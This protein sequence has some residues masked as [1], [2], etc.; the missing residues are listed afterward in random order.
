MRE[1]IVIFL[2]LLTVEVLSAQT[3][4]GGILVEYSSLFEKK[5]T[6]KTLF[7]IG[8]SGVEAHKS[9][10]EER[11]THSGVGLFYCLKSDI[12]C[13]FNL[14]LRPGILLIEEPFFAPQI[15]LHLRYYANEGFYLGTGLTLEIYGSRETD[16]EPPKL[17]LSGSVSIGK[18]ILKKLW[19][20]FSA[21]KTVDENYGSENT[22]YSNPQVVISHH[23]IGSIKL[24]FEYNL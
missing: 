1:L 12:G 16:Y 10:V 4:S 13:G 20:V 3:F 24:G 5:N 6:A 8:G 11:Q 7:V 22:K 14:E 17:P 18:E 2:V 15:G 19:L 23:L 21:T 9:N